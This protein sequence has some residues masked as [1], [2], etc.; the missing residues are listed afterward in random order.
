MQEPVWLKRRI[1]DAVHFDQLRQHGGAS[2]VR[3]ENA[4]E[5]ALSRPR[6]KWA[7]EPQS[8]LA[9]LAAAFGFGLAKNHAYNDGNKRVAFMAMYIFLG[10]NGWEIAASE[11]EAVQVMLSLASSRIDEKGLTHWLRE[12]MVEASF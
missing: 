6:S 4:L 8:D 3:D 2:G 1:A 9:V 12:H 10:L 5:S 7:Y 11:E